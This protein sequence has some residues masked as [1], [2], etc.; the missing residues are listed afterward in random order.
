VAQT[1]SSARALLPFCD[2][3][4]LAHI[5]NPSRSRKFFTT[6]EKGIKDAMVCQKLIVSHLGWV[7]N[8]D[9]VSQITEFL[10]TYKGMRYAFCTG[11][12]NERIQFLKYNTWNNRVKKIV[13]LLES[14][15]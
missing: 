11:R 14:I 4:I 7:E 1:T 10:L 9:L 6:L 12:Y 13:N 3:R 2:M 8:P 5:Q 15:D